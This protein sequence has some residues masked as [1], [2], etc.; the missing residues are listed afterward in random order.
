[1]PMQQISAAF[2]PVQPVENIVPSSKVDAQAM[3]QYVKENK[4]EF[5]KQMKDAKKGI[6]DTKAGTNQ[7]LCAIIAFFIPFLG[8]GLWTGITKEFWISLLL[9]LLFWLPGVI[10][11]FYVILFRG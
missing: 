9:T 10:Y 8:V 2:L 1:M 5:K 3:R 11:A 4:K 6:K 7:V